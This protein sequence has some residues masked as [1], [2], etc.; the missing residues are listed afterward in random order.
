MKVG[1]VW[2]HTAPLS[3]CSFRFEE[4]V[5]GLEALS[6]EEESDLVLAQGF[7]QKF[8]GDFPIQGGVF[9]EIDL[10]HPAPPQA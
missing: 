6:C 3:Q 10:G 5:R 1:I 7:R 8:Q 4:Y 2:A 9:S